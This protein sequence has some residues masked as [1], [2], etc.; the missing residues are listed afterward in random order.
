MK[1]L[2]IQLVLCL[3][4]FLSVQCKEVS[5]PK[6][7]GYFR[8]NFPEHEYDT[9]QHGFPYSF[10]Y[11][12]YTKIAK[13]RSP[14]AEAYWIN[15]EYP[16]YRGKIHL[17]YKSVDN[18][19]REILEDSRR[20]AYKHSIKADAIGEKLF[21]APEK[22][23]YGILYDIKGDAASSVQFFLTDSVRNFLRGSLYFNVIPNKDSL[24]PVVDFVKEDI[25]HLMETFEWK[26]LSDN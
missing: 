15:I 20:L 6:P 22:K 24:A 2:R 3:F 11:P 23:V 12:E 5:T 17:S 21:E 8:I 13:D 16:E 9:L 7:R 18:N 19:L 25:Y 14:S 4:A 26:S 10:E 1:F